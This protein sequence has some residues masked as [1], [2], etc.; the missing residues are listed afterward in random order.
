MVV[1]QRVSFTGLENRDNRSEILTSLL[2]LFRALFEKNRR[3]ANI[4]LTFRSHF[5]R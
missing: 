5:V 4:Y 1:A 3:E 2:D